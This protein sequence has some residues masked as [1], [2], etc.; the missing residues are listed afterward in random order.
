MDR[1][2]SWATVHRVAKS[3][4]WLKW[5]STRLKLISAD[6]PAEEANTRLP[7][8]FSGQTLLIKMAS[9]IRKSRHNLWILNT[10]TTK[11]IKQLPGWN[12]HGLDLLPR[13]FCSNQ[14]LIRLQSLSSGGTIAPGTSRWMIYKVPL[15]VFY[16]LF[17]LKLRTDFTLVNLL[18]FYVVGRF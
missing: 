16:I 4:T 10:A 13:A 2:A 8:P 17:P 18:R 14:G 15:K 12:N 1:G 9:L 7:N 5:L 6:K 3:R 11:Q